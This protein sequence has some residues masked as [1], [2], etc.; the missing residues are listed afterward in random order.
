LLRPSFNYEKPNY[1]FANGQPLSEKLMKQT[2]ELAE[3]YTQE[4]QWQDGDIVIINNKRVLHGRRAI[5][6]NLSDRALFIG[7]GY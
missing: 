4:I 2:A 3:K 5:T 7:M 6:G 1:S